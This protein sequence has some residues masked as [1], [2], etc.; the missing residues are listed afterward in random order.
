MATLPVIPKKEGKED[1]FPKQRL[2]AKE[3]FAVFISAIQY[4]RYVVLWKEFMDMF[5]KKGKL[6]DI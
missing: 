4:P 5:I 6:C 1:Y 3:T 2:L